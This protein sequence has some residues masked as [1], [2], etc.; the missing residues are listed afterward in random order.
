MYRLIIVGLITLF[1]GACRNENRIGEFRMNVQKHPFAFIFSNSNQAE[2]GDVVQSLVTKIRNDEVSGVVPSGLNL[3]VF[4]PS[5]L[6]ELFSLEARRYLNHFNQNGNGSFNTYPGFVTNFTHYSNSNTFLDEISK[7]QKKER[8]DISI[9]QILVLKGNAITI[10]IK[11]K[12]NEDVNYKHHLEIFAYNKEQKSSQ[13][14]TNGTQAQFT[15]RNVVQ[16][17]VS[18]GNGVNLR[19]RKKGEEVDLQYE[20]DAG[21][22]TVNQTGIVSVL[23][24]YNNDTPTEVINSYSN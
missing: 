9:G 21:S 11:L 1:F 8:T 4:H 16:S 18:S 5:E 14:T 3:V 10:R 13:E 24:K 12:Y 2:S 20:F 19:S 23:I 15:H 17:S 6:D 22:I 7:E